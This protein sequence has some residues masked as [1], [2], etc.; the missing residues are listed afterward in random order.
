MKIDTFF[1][2]CQF[3]LKG[4]RK[5]HRLMFLAKKVTY[6]LFVNKDNSPKYLQSFYLPGDIQAITIQKHYLKQQK[7]LSRIYFDHQVKN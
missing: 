1:H 4:T 6:E 2:E 5:L 3:F 7:R